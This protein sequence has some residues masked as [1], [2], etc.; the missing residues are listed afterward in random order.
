MHLAGEVLEEPVELLGVAIGG[1]AGNSAGS[2]SETS[3]LDL[4]D[5]RDQLAA[6]AFD[7]SE[8]RMASPRL[9]PCR[10]PVDLAEG[11]RRIEPLLSRSS[12]LR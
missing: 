5:L 11:T 9:E 7:P 3:I 12:K 2:S 10:Q 6:K 1:R 4:L 8:T